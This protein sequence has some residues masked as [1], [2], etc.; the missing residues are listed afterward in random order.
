MA[1]HV[2][3]PDCRSID[4]LSEVIEGANRGDTVIVYNEILEVE[5]ERIAR[6]TNCGVVVIFRPKKESAPVSP[7]P[8]QY[9][10]KIA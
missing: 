2:M 9:R 10:R 7:V 5:G 4:A 1:I 8:R 6:E 3:D